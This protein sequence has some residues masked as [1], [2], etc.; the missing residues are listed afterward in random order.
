M[1]CFL[2]HIVSF[3]YK[4]WLPCAALYPLY[5]LSYCSESLEFI[6]D[7]NTCFIVVRKKV[8]FHQYK[9]RNIETLIAQILRIHRRSYLAVRTW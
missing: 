3:M 4:H 2:N 7:R 5:I 6:S 8:Y 9:S 1:V